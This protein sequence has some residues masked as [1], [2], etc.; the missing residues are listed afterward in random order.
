MKKLF[1]AITALIFTLPVIAQTS[2]SDGSTSPTSTGTPTAPMGSGSMDTDQAMPS[3]KAEME[4]ESEEMIRSTGP[5]TDSSIAQPP[6][7][8]EER[9]EFEDDSGVNP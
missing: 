3:S 6:Q 8:E 9:T 1:F 4:E 5:A 2:A 7:A